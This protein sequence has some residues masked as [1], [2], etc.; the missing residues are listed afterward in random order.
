MTTP[1]GWYEDP[2]APGGG[3][4][5]WW[6]GTR[7]TEHTRPHPGADQGA[8]HQQPY[9]QPGYGHQQPYGQQGYSQAPQQYGGYPA[10]PAQ[11]GA[12]TAAKPTHTPDG[13]PLAHQGRRLVAW[14]LD[15]ILIG[16]LQSILLA[17]LWGDL[18]DLFDRYVEE[19]DRSVATGEPVDPLFL[20]TDPAYT[21]F[22]VWSLVTTIVVSAVYA[23]L[24]IRLVG[25]TVGQLAL[26]VRVRAFDR[27]GNPS[28]GAASLRWVVEYP[29]QALC[30]IWVV[31]DGVWCLFDGR[32]QTLHD[33]A[34]STV[35]VRKQ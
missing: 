16:I 11:Y 5:R 2:G 25:A 13:V 28:W 9:G 6:D 7:W 12:G 3:Q 34:A 26:G 31:L 27:P 33:K 1:A 35:V 23:I 22:V 29:A 14:L 10:A 15:G 17:P 24:M 18:F 30:G 8:G 21:S 20:T 19:V 4:V 32:R